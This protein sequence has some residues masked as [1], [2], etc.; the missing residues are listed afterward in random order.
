MAFAISD[1][2]LDVFE[3]SADMWSCD[4]V[5]A[6]VDGSFLSQSIAISVPAYAIALGSLA[7]ENYERDLLR[8]T[9]AAATLIVLK[10]LQCAW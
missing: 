7:K 5:C 4:V 6:S 2:A 8:M 10:N 9:L 1:P 3:D